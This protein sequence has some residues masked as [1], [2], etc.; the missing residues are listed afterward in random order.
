MLSIKDAKEKVN[1]HTGINENSLKT[2]KTN[3]GFIWFETL[4]NEVSIKVNRNGNHCI[5]DGM[6]QEFDSRKGVIF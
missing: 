2:V 1:E 6:I 5:V 4:D 3:S